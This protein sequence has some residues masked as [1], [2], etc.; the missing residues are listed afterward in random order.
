MKKVFFLLTILLFTQMI[1]ALEIYVAPVNVIDN[2][3]NN[4]SSESFEF[5]RKLAESLSSIQ[6]NSTILFQY[7]GNQGI[8]DSF[9]NAMQFCNV[10]DIKYLLYGYIERRGNS[11]YSEIRLLDYEGKSVL[12]TFFS[13][14]SK[15][16]EDRIINDLAVKVTDYIETEYG[17]ASSLRDEVTRTFGLEIPLSIGYWTPAQSAWTSTVTG[18]VNV[19]LGITIVPDYFATSLSNKRAYI[20]LSVYTGYRYALGDPST[21]D[22]SFHAIDTLFLPRY[23]LVLSDVHELY[24]GVGLMYSLNLYSI[25]EKFGSEK[26][27]VDGIPGVCL[28]LGYQFNV[29]EKIGIILD[30]TF[31]YLLYSPEMFVWSPKL[32]VT[33][34]IYQRT[35]EK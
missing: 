15:G 2:G 16:Q 25:T 17:Y 1:S 14:D 29:T 6:K 3:L 5:S 33:Y 18:T 19:M 24:L 20:S 11:I 23:H 35:M 4:R 30:N 28:S 21:Y 32:G 34:K 8:P 31:L 9:A 12:A 7:E 27:S 10:N 13:A 22:L 26:E